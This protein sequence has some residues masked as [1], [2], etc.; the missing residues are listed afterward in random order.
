MISTVDFL[1][2]RSQ[3]HTLTKYFSLNFAGN[4]STY[5]FVTKSL[6]VDFEITLYNSMSKPAQ[7]HSGVFFMKLAL[8]S[9]VCEPDPET[10]GE[11]IE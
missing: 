8:R 6:T 10:L 11:T 7:R 9:V 2:F 3:L 4:S 5:T 1:L